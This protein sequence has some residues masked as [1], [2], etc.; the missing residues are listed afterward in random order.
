M[1]VMIA[2]TTVKIVVWTNL[3]NYGLLWHLF[4]YLLYS[5]VSCVHIKYV[6]SFSFKYSVRSNK[7]NKHIHFCFIKP[8]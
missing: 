8:I 1:Y 6:Y 4:W 2:V 5:Y 3:I 7:L